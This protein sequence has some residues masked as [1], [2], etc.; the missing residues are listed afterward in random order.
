MGFN[1]A[2]IRDPVT[3]R[4]PLGSLYYSLVKEVDKFILKKDVEEEVEAPPWDWGEG[5]KYWDGEE[6]ESES[7]WEEV[8][9]K[10]EDRVSSAEG[11]DGGDGLEK[12]G[13]DE[14]FEGAV[15]VDAS[16]QEKQVDDQGVE[17]VKDGLMR[18]SIEERN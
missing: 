7:E 13:G 3:G 1:L 15:M 9:M 16:V 18:M 8:G 2:K 14:G 6:S 17:G 10:M 12:Q 5:G 4:D 11:F